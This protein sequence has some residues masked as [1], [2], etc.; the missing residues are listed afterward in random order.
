[1]LNEFDKKAGDW[2]KN[3]IHSERSE[4]IARALLQKLAVE[5]DMKVLEYGAGTG[6]LSFLMKDRFAEITLMDSSAEMIRIVSEKIDQQQALHLKP[7]L[8]N[9]EKEDFQGVFDMIYSQMVFHHVE[10]LP[11]LLFKFSQMIRAGGFMAIADL[12]P[13][14]GSFHGEGFTGHNGFDPD[15]LASL[16][17]ASGFDRVEYQ[18]CYT[19]RKKTESGEEKEYPVFLMTAVKS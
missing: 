10:D 6:L 11:A 7:L 5:P 4:A 13:E 8:I 9:L 14:D 16:L 12:Y 2:D 1:M 17:Q 3:P 19:I 18:P 15:G